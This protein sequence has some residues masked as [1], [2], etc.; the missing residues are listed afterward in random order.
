MCAEDTAKEP[1]F[2]LFPRR[3]DGP[4]VEVTAKGMHCFAYHHVN[5]FDV[6]EEGKKII[7]DTC[8]WDVFNLY[9]KDIVEPDGTNHFPRTKLSR[10]ELDTETGIATHKVMDRTPCEYPT[11]APKSTG[12]PYRCALIHFT[13]EIVL[14]HVESGL[15]SISLCNKRLTVCIASGSCPLGYCEERKG[16]ELKK[17]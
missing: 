6:D 17:M 11:V 9:F 8:T 3:K 7:F 5:G 15:S 13:D 12:V 4:M 14:I 2:R 16:F 10:F 1:V